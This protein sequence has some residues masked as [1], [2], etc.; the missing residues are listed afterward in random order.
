MGHPPEPNWRYNQVSVSQQ[1][2]ALLCI[3]IM[4]L[5]VRTVDTVVMLMMM[6]SRDGRSDI[7]GM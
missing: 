6:I 2:Y 7:N 1:H 5:E 3:M 4:Y